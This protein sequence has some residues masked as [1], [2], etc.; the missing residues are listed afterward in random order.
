MLS[1]TLVTVGTLSLSLSDGESGTDTLTLDEEYFL[2][3]GSPWYE[4]EESLSVGIFGG[5]ADHSVS[6][7]VTTGVV[8]LSGYNSYSDS[9]YD[10]TVTVKAILIGDDSVRTGFQTPVLHTRGT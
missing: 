8:T 3:F 6:Y 1:I 10:V 5:G 4:I 2:P 7:N 9:Q